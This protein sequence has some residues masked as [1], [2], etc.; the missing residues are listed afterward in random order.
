M[1]ENPKQTHNTNLYPKE[2]YSFTSAHPI[3]CGT[4]N[5]SEWNG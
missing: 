3:K 5:K 2:Y 4:K 1:V